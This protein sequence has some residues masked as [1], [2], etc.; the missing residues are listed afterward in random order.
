MKNTPQRGVFHFAVKNNPPVPQLEEMM[1]PALARWVLHLDASNFPLKTDLVY[2]PEYLLPIIK[3]GFR[4][5]RAPY[6]A[7]CI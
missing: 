7:D 5:N 2:R 6:T 4:F 1:N 3:C